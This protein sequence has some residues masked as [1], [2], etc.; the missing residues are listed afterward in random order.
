M[1][2]YG[3]Q[4]TLKNHFFRKKVQKITHFQDFGGNFI[5]KWVHPPESAKSI[6]PLYE[7]AR[8]WGVDAFMCKLHNSKEYPYKTYSSNSANCSCVLTPCIWY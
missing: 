7:F 2:F 1:Y 3:G 6:D 8:F 4:K 5:K